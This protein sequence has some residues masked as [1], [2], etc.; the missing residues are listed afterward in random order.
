MEHSQHTSSIQ[1]KKVTITVNNMGI[2]VEGTKDETILQT[3]KKNDSRFQ[4]LCGGKGICGK[5]KMQ[6]ISGKINDFK[7][8][9]KFFTEEEKKEGYR[10]ACLTYPKSNCVIDWKGQSETNFDVVMEY[11]SVNKVDEQSAELEV[12]QVSDLTI[13][14]RKDQDLDLTHASI[15]EQNKLNGTSSNFGIAIDIGTTTIGMQLIDLET[16]VVCHN[17]AVMN[18]Q[19]CYGADVISRIEAAN[20][21][22]LYE[23]KKCIRKTIKEGIHQVL[24]YKNLELQRVS[25][26]V[27]AANTTMIHLFMGYSCESLGKYPYTPVNIE[28]I[29]TTYKELWK[30][31]NINSQLLEFNPEVIIIPGIST[32][33]GGDIVSGLLQCEF[34]IK[35]KPCILI[36]LGTNGE[37]ALGDAKGITVASTAAGTAFEGGNISCGIGSI[38]GAISNVTIDN[39][40]AVV[41]TIGN[42]SPIGICGTGVIEAVA[43]LIK[44]GIVDESGLLE[45]TW[46]EEGFPLAKDKE[47][48]TIVITQ[49][50]IREIQLAKSA[51]RAGIEALLKFRGLNYSEI[52]SVYIA[53]GFGFRL[54]TRKAIAIGLLPMEWKDKVKTAGNTSLGGGIRYLINSYMDERIRK[55]ISISDELDL[56]RNKDFQEYFVKYMMF[57]DSIEA[58]E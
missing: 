34:D 33:V 6:L 15:A 10:L 43:E 3:L 29:T 49:K 56:G 20:Q 31:D 26:I 5:C 58:R 14:Q 55:I 11:V 40:N 44:A 17:Y 4:A 45:D 21:G 57:D 42:G 27:I 51:I 8:D 38:K 28:R 50:D 18:P 39:S 1:N 30:V 2:S 41:K 48:K 23:L 19:R 16:G 52:D 36:D 54:D 25:K 32:Y 53:G 22:S 35:Q 47:G 37:M 9:K 46:F 12:E 24:T 13:E 7:E